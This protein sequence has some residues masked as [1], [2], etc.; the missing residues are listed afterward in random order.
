MG[1]EQNLKRIYE[2]YADVNLAEAVY[3]TLRDGILQ[4][5]IQGGYKLNE[6]ELANTFKVSRTPIQKALIRLECDCLIKYEPKCGYIVEQMDFKGC[7]D[8]NEYSLLM[9]TASAILAVR[10]RFSAYYEMVLKKRLR[11]L[12]SISDIP[13]YLTM[14]DSFHNQIAASTQNDE[15]INAFKK[16]TTRGALM[17]LLYSQKVPSHE[18]DFIANHNVLINQFFELLCNGSVTELVGFMENT[19]CPHL[20]NLVTHWCQEIIELD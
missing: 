5:S 1:A 6:M 15:L 7:V 14:V 3:M 13:T 19:Y 11:E 17:G 20:R 8:F 2:K 9:Y 18:T 10:R 4:G 16:T 12:E